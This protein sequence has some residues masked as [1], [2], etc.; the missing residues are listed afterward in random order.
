MRWN[1]RSRLL[2]ATV[3]NAW[4]R[5][6]FRWHGREDLSDREGAVK[7]STALLCASVVVAFSV[8][9]RHRPAGA[10]DADPGRAAYL[11][12]CS[13]CHGADGKGD[14]VASSAMRPKPA[15]LT[16]LANAHGGKF[17]FT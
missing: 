12:Y 7:Q 10:A 15:D 11:K 5:F 14:G 9:L 13:A 1:W 3:G 16:Q 4:H 17:P 6:R 2:D 8:M